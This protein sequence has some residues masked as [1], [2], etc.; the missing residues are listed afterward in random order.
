MDAVEV[1]VGDDFARGRFEIVGQRDNVV[2]IPADTTAH[3]QK[4]LRQIRQYTGDFVRNCLGRMVM[5]SIE[6]EEFFARDGVAQ[7]KLMRARMALSLCASVKPCG[8]SFPTRP[9]LYSFRNT[10]PTKVLRTVK[11]RVQAAQAKR[12]QTLSLKKQT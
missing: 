8:M 1:I 3:V 11:P 12:T 10:A 4:N 6:A 9:T 7:I 2:A 5:A